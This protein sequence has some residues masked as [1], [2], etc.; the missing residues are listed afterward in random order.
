M[1]ELAQEIGALLVLAWGVA[2]VW[3]GAWVRAFRAPDG[4]LWEFPAQDGWML[5][6]HRY[7]PQGVARGGPP[8]ILGHG[9]MM[10]R[11]CW[12]LSEAG[13]LP[14]ALSRRGHDVYVAEYRGS[15]E[16]ARHPS[17]GLQRRADGFDGWSFDD[18]VQLDLPAIIDGVRTISGSDTVH[19]VGHSMGGMAGYAYAIS[20]G[21]EK[22]ASLVTLG[23]PARFGHIK[24]LFGPTGPL[25]LKALRSMRRL[26]IR[27]LIKLLLPFT[28]IAPNLSMRTS[29]PARYLSLGERLTLMAEAFEDTSPALAGF[30]IDHSLNDRRLI[31]SDQ[32]GPSFRDLTVPTLI[33]GGLH[34]VLAP[35]R[36][37]RVPLDEAEPGRVAYR[38]FGDPT[39][40]ADQAG[41]GLGHSDLI[42]GETAMKHVLPVLAR[43]LEADDP[44]SLPEFFT[45]SA[46]SP[47]A[48]AV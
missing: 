30:F 32:H 35:P 1:I 18:H 13:S 4:E 31:P 27:P 22:L 2:A 21:G 36:A 26:R 45:N 7:P 24:R 8:V 38:L 41:P 44:L 19:W 25:A 43:W 29:G 16:S 28:A 14:L 34:D 3:A 5:H 48:K 40:P 20:T 11:W 39:L 37:H 42:S 12:S 9:F 33:L 47:L 15:G 17:T 10:N 46:D 6:V 23:S